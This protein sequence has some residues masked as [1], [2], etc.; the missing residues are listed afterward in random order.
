MGVDVYVATPYDTN[1]VSAELSFGGYTG[2][3]NFVSIDT[4]NKLAGDYNWMVVAN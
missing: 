3:M 2:K 1:F 4:S